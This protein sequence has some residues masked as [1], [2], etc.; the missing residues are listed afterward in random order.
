MFLYRFLLFYQ[1]KHSGGHDRLFNRREQQ[2]WGAQHHHTLWR[3]RAT[4]SGFSV[5]LYSQP[6]H[7]NGSAIKKL[8]QVVST[9]KIITH[10][11]NSK[12]FILHSL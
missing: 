9:Q 5:S 12:S 7:H 1:P 3:G 10:C 2:D 4:S 6:E 11:L 8:S